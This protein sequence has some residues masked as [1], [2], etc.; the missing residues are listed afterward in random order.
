VDQS[1]P[2]FLENVGG[3]VADNSVFRLSIS[4]FVLEILAIIL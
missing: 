3:I 2:I 4:L 1:S